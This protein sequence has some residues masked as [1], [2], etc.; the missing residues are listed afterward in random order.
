MTRVFGLDLS[1]TASGIA[2]PPEE[3]LPNGYEV[4]TT[5]ARGAER[6]GEITAWVLAHVTSP[7]ADLVVI[8]GPGYFKGDA[9]FVLELHGAVKLML[10]EHDIEYVMVPP[11][12]L[13]KFTTGKGN[14][15]KDVMLA[16]AIRTWGFEGSNNN[17]ADA[18]MLRCMG[19]EQYDPA[20]E[21]VRRL[22]KPRIDALRTVE[23][24]DLS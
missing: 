21:T 2:G 1:L 13:K 17:E 6:L 7:D 5:K 23:W 19:H 12:V 20:L 22:S 24:P 15:D 8:E 9:V 4:Y 3:W 10:W 11:T 18:W 14:V 16:T